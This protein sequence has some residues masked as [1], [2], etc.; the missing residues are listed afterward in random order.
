[1]RIPT[2]RLALTGGAIVILA[3]AGVGLVAASSNV[4]SEPRAVGAA[5]PSA[6]PATGT[7]AGP[8]RQRLAQRLGRVAAGRP[9]AGHL[10]HATSRSPT[11]TATS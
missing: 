11:R 8:L 2:W 6:G 9:F 5:A 7:G 3:V 1:M 10:V 4:G